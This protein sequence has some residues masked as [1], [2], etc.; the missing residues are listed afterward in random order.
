MEDS[1]ADEFS[2]E[3]TQKHGILSTSPDHEKMGKG[4]TLTA[5]ELTAL[6]AVL[7][8]MQL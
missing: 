3:I 8:N 5:E 6:K 2:Y 4:V 1:M 7:N